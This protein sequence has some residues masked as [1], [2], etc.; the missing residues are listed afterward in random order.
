MIGIFAIPDV[1]IDCNNTQSMYNLKNKIYDLNDSLNLMFPCWSWI[2]N[3]SC[4][5]N[6][7]LIK[8]ELT[9][10]IIITHLIF[11][12]L[13]ISRN[14]IYYSKNKKILIKWTII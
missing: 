12:L 3:E 13:N 4:T 14:L 1:V 7:I 10:D 5:E 8:S 11:L 2:S 6:D 9:E